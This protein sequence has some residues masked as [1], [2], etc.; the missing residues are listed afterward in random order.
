MTWMYSRLARSSEQRKTY[1]MN[2]LQHAGFWGL[3]PL[4]F[5]ARESVNKMNVECLS[6]TGRWVLLLLLLF[7]VGRIERS[8]S[9]DMNYR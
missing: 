2:D 7:Q 4:T 5:E 3:Q 9:D 8:V 6:P 1:M